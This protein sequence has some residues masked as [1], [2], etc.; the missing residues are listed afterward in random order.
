MLRIPRFFLPPFPKGENPPRSC[1][2]LLSHQ[3][4]PIFSWI[5]PFPPQPDLGIPN[6][7][8]FFRNSPNKFFLEKLEFFS[9]T[10]WIWGFGCCFFGFFP[11]GFAGK[12][13]DGN[14][15]SQEFLIPLNPSFPGIFFPAVFPYFS[16]LDFQELSQTLGKSWKSINI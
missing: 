8:D 9:R 7:E 5:F 3:K 12:F 2:F 13:Q 6:P 11:S 10:S 15:E 1:K 16:S 4:I 14:E